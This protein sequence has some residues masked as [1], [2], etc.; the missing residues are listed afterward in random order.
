M[1]LIPPRT[2]FPGR[3]AC[4]GLV[5]LAVLAATLPALAESFSLDLRPPATGHGAARRAAASAV[6]EQGVLRRTVLPAGATATPDLAV[7]DDLSLRLFDDAKV[8]VVIAE[9]ADSPLGGEAFLAGAMDGRLSAVVLQTAEGLTIDAQ[10]ADEGRVFTVV[11]SAAGV[12]VREYDPF[13]GEEAPC[14]PVEPRPS[15]AE[16]R[17][18][19]SSSDQPGGMVDVLV[20][21]DG[22][23]AEWA[24]EYG[25]GTTNFATVSVQKMNIALA[26]SGLG[27]EF[28]YRLVG[29]RELAVSGGADLGGVLDATQAGSGAWAAVKAAR[30][31]CG[32]DVVTT[33]IDTGSAF[34][35]VGIGFG[36]NQRN[37]SYFSSMAY[38]VC[39]I[40]SVASKHTMTHE[41]GHNLGAGH[42]T[43]V[44]PNQIAA[45]PQYFS[46][47]AGHYFTG[48]DGVAYHTI[49]AY[50][51][52]GY[53]GHYE[54]APLFSS[55]SV[56]YQGAAAGD[57]AH[58]NANTLR[59][60]WAT[61]AGWR[62]QKVPTSWDVFFSP[63]S[64]T[65][66][67]GSLTVT[68]TPGK[69]G[70]PIRYTL[71]GSDPT[72]SSPLY[73]E[74]LT[75]TEATTVKAATFADGRAGPVFQAYYGPDPIA[76]A[77]DAT[78]LKWTNDLDYPWSVRTD[79]AY[80]GASAMRSGLLSE[81]THGPTE[82][83]TV[84][85]GQTRMS[86]RYRKH[87][88]EGGYFAIY[89]SPAGTTYTPTCVFIDSVAGSSTE[90]RLAECE[91]PAGRQRVVFQ[92]RQGDWIYIDDGGNYEF[93]GV[94]L[95]TVR[96]D[97]LS[98]PPSISPPSSS[99]EARARTFT[100]VLEVTLT[101]P[102]GRDGVLWYTTDGSDPVGANGLAY[103]GDDPI[104]FNGLVYNGPFTITNSTRVRAAFVEPGLEPSAPVDVVYLKRE[105]VVPGK[106]TP[107]ADGARTA[108]A[109]DPSARLVAVLLSTVRTDED[110][111]LFQP[112]ANDPDFLEWAA[113]NGVYL[114]VS[115]AGQFL[116]SQKAEQWFWELHDVWTG[117]SSVADIPGIY[118]VAPKSPDMPFAAGVAIADGSSMIDAVTYDGT[119]ASLIAGFES[120]LRSTPWTVRFSPNGGT[121]SMAP[122]VFRRGV[123]APLNANAF[124]RLGWEFT[125]WSLIP[126]G[127][128]ACYDRQ[129]VMD[130]SGS[131]DEITLYAAWRGIAYS[132]VLHENVPRERTVSQP[133]RYGMWTA[134][135]R[136]PFPRGGHVLLGWA[137]SPSGN[138]VFGD[139]QPVVNLA[140]TPGAR[141]HLYARWARR[142]YRVAFS[143][144]GGKGRM[145]AR[146]MTYGV[147]SALPANRFKRRKYVFIGW[148]RTRGGP[149]AY[150]NGQSVANL[151]A[152]G[153]TVTLHAQW[154]RDS[155]RIAFNSNGGKGRMGKCKV[156]YG[157]GVRLPGN[158]FTRPGYVFAGWSRT[159]GG[160]VVYRN[161]QTVA[162]LTAGGGT[163]TLYAV[164]R[165]Q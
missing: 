83:E 36:L 108:A 95:D 135:R 31:E 130:L 121:G 136:N 164:W 115:D 40:R 91:I 16:R 34:G 93:N 71:D 45:G 99:D 54:L 154:A 1:A 19:A 43:A 103:G 30:D 81:Y 24:R 56:Q 75:I 138:A 114:V 68:L 38:N 158:R 85:E 13:A 159:R 10:D 131:A 14:E 129:T 98:R 92:F 63:A 46:D 44:N 41:C 33:L 102:E 132:A 150:R 124:R 144:N 163:V 145:D 123:A 20:A 101:P 90:W 73:T 156:A 70:L 52:D 55:P 3:L 67:A 84:I 142:D 160:P 35:V 127:A 126:N 5:W 94:W 66:I 165:R 29:V 25:G 87:F 153:G 100:D 72:A 21:F 57:A 140:S 128:V 161:G 2:I 27:A 110:C 58:D 51:F 59:R 96:F 120:A 4:A 18:A 64:G 69:A 109:A 148:S 62:Q 141:V 60:T 82:I 125:G 53:G 88:A 122:Q 78:H 42:A 86:F 134:L 152:D 111:A 47:S 50:N 149:V 112:V 146:A 105:P 49:M 117:N 116:E 11:S 155:Y 119:A 107:D 22:P 74:P 104:G 23:A 7:G 37:V 15:A 76:L 79:V 39:S 9:R 133:L 12:E 32:A 17:A 65:P 8:D 28:R 162:N 118:F 26:N 157:S 139:A 143:A 97:A 151:T 6:V 61:A 80:D 89:A 147:P 113:A 106:W 137:R 48:R 77:L